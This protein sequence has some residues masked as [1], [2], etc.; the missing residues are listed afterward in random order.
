MSNEPLAAIYEKLPALRQVRTVIFDWSGTLCDD[1][2]YLASITNFVRRKL[3]MK[4]LDERQL[5]ETDCLPLADYYKQ[6]FPRADAERVRE[7]YKQARMLNENA[8][9][10][11]RSLPC[12]I[13]LA[14]YLHEQG[15]S[16]RIFAEEQRSVIGRQ[17]RYIRLARY[18]KG[19]KIISGG[20][21]DKIADLPLYLQQM[22]L[23]PESVLYVGD[24]PHDV[25]AGRAAG[26]MTCCMQTGYTTPSRMRAAR[27]DLTLNDFGQLHVLFMLAA[28]NEPP[29]TPT[30][31]EQPLP[32][33]DAG[34]RQQS[35]HN[36]KRK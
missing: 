20:H 10:T 7:L 17:L 30:T 23:P 21:M 8:E 15:I 32:A 36:Q 29:A 33:A 24:T 31:D 12:A 1:L 34:K 2:T 11:V 5:L 6:Q 27:P 3:G 9:H 18:F 28:I 4:Q 22:G 13:M 26:V 35:T 19:A 25:L 14:N 16:I